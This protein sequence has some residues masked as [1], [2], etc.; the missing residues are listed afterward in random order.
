MTRGGGFTPFN[1]L[2]LRSDVSP[3]LK[4]SFETTCQFL[5]DATLDG[6]ND[7]LRSPSARIVLGRLSKVGTGSFDVLTRVS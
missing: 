2:G 7:D 1:R 5:K 6:D 3:F 4:M